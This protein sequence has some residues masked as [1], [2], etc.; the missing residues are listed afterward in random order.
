MLQVAIGTYAQDSVSKESVPKDQW[1]YLYT[2]V[3]VSV[4]ALTRMEKAFEIQRYVDANGTHDRVV[5]IRSLF[6]TNHIEKIVDSQMNLD[7][8]RNAQA[9]FTMGLAREKKWIE[10]VKKLNPSIQVVD[11][12]EKCARIPGNPYLWMPNG[13][14]TWLTLTAHGALIGDKGAFSPICPVITPYAD[15]LGGCPCIVVTHPALVYVGGCN[16]FGTILAE[17]D[18]VG[19]TKFDYQALVEQAK[20]KKV[21]RV[22]AVRFSNYERG[23]RLA[24]DIGAKFVM[25]QMDDLVELELNLCRITVE[26]WHEQNMK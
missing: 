4:P 25:L 6:A 2:N 13:N 14:F 18:E 9:Y 23:E 8:A 3:V 11:I 20:R 26:G 19:R 7:A 17:I 24:A 22:F 12:S 5:H 21:N 15:H 1:P 10:M 16:L